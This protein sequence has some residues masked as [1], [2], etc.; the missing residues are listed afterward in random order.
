MSDGVQG[1]NGE[2]NAPQ[3]MVEEVAQRVATDIGDGAMDIATN[4]MAATA[5]EAIGVTKINTVE[6]N[7][8]VSASRVAP[9]T[10]P[11]KIVDRRPEMD[12]A[13]TCPE[14]VMQPDNLAA[15]VVEL[16]TANPN[17]LCL[18]PIC[19]TTTLDTPAESSG[20]T[21]GDARSSAD[22]A[23]LK[24][25]E[26]EPVE[27]EP[28][29]SNAAGPA[30]EQP[31]KR[32]EAPKLRTVPDLRTDVFTTPT[33]FHFASSV[34]V[35]RVLERLVE[36]A[37]ASN[38]PLDHVLLHGPPGCGTTLVARAIVRDLAPKNFVELDLLD[39][40]DQEMLRRAVREVRNQ[41]VLL[42]RHIELMSSGDEQFL[43]SCI[44]RKTTRGTGSFARDIVTPSTPAKRKKQSIDEFQVDATPRRSPPSFPRI[45]G[46]FTL[47]ATAHLTQ[48]IGYQLRHRFDH[49]IHLRS[50][51]VG[52]RIA[53]TRVLTRH[54][55]VVDESAH[56]PIERFTR[57][58][59]DV[60][61]QF[62]RAIVMRAQLDETAHI[63][64]TLVRSVVTEDMP[65]RIADEVYGWAL[66]RHLAGRRVT[67]VTD[68]EVE[69]IDTETG[70]GEVAVRAALGV[71]VRNAAARAVPPAA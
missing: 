54:G 27:L 67:A 22:P 23:K 52:V 44:A 45:D 18:S 42:I 35:T 8:A 55:F 24:P 57:T 38:R 39:G 43:M 62:V 56:A 25:V 4:G 3:N 29:H 26:H 31:A 65:A 1:G 28:V 60:A 33:L 2:K 20:A 11:A 37:L 16:C 14:H 19:D 68:N 48:Q 5:S 9:E 63:D 47:I 15:D 12:L 70:W 32:G 6:L 30:Y 21:K 13:D 59:D 71:I 7:D 41:G 10:S 51:A 64:D 61:D 58:I 46:N 69:R 66:T 40:V 53:I 17:P 49:M 34:G 50:D 36:N